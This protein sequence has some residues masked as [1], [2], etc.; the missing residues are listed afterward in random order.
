MRV[1]GNLQHIFGLYAYN[2][3]MDT[4][5][6]FYL[7]RNNSGEI[8]PC[9]LERIRQEHYIL[10][11][12]GLSRTWIE[13][14]KVAG[15]LELLAQET[16]DNA[17]GEIGEAGFFRR[18]RER[19]RLRELSR[20]RQ[21]ERELLGQRLRRVGELIYPM[22]EYPDESYC[23]YDENLKKTS[24]HR[25][26]QQ[27]CSFPEFHDYMQDTWAEPLLQYAEHSS[28]L[29]LGY[30]FCLPGFLWQRA[31][32]MKSLQ[33]ILPAKLYTEEI[34]RFE[35]DICQEFGLVIDMHIVQSTEEYR[36]V[37][38]TSRFPV[39]VID[40]S[41]E[42]RLQAADLPTESIWLDMA[43]MEEKRRR[44]EDRRCPMQYF[45]LK[46]QWNKL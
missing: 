9:T 10:L 46:K 3:S 35:E 25:L 26:W 2:G 13:K 19:R 6:Y 39:N 31:D 17:N 40:F 7:D 18:L 34:A 23:V 24:F 42:A 28:Y 4:I 5:L 43:S 15:A 1:Y 45:S 41:G 12:I 11:R 22:L 16:E 44:I 30:A 29:V 32:R 14:T 8:Q 20:Q 38:L 27:F 36:R 21:A 33:W 37:K